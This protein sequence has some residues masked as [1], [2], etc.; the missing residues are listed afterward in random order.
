VTTLLTAGLIAKTW[1]VA[2]AWMAAQGTILAIVALALTRLAGRLRPA[3][4][5]AIWLVVVVKFALPWGPGLRWSLSDLFALLTRSAPPLDVV[6]PLPPAL[7]PLPPPPHAWPA[8]AWLVLAIIWVTGATLV[9]A[10]AI[11]AHRRTVV[12]ARTSQLAPAFAQRLVAQLAAQLKVRAPELRIGAADVGPHVIGFVRTTIVVPPALIADDATTARDTNNLLRA[13]LLHELA[14]VRRRDVLGRAAQV[15]A[16][17]LL[18][19]WPIVRVVGRRLDA[20]RETACDAWALEAGALAR[21][22]YARLLVRMAELRAAAAPSLAAPHALNARV[23]AVLGPM[24]HAHITRVQRTVL[25]A[26]ALL[27]LGG[28][29][30]ASAHP[31]R[32]ACKYTPELAQALYLSYPEADLDGDGQL[33]RDEACGLQAELRRQGSASAQ[34]Q[35]VS[36]LDPASEA[37]LQ[38]WLEEPLCCNCETPEANS[39]TCTQVGADPR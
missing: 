39:A 37:E 13:A 35:L 38:T 24:S 32:V 25:A 2:L 7:A 10:R 31:D 16:I 9:I 5:A 15:A 8:I 28:A 27:A 21:P 4:Q 20:A 29:R 26:F 14:H 11:R 23:A 6:S 12:A 1:L 30:T 33:S 34:P 22:T 3:W 18:W 17:A 36:H 19:F